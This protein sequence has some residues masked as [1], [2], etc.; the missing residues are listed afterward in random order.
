MAQT[1]FFVHEK[2]DNVGVAV[3]DIKA[4]ENVNGWLMEDDEEIAIKSTSDIPLGHKIALNDISKGS[5][6]LK[7]NVVIGQA[8]QDIKQGEHVHTQNLKTMRW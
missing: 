7:Y 8:T 3:V 5:K 2:E 1:H 4:G 6:V